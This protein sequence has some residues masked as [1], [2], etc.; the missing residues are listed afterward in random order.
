M[1]KIYYPYKIKTKEEFISDYGDDWRECSKDFS[2]ILAMD[3]LLGTTLKLTSDELKEKWIVSNNTSQ[4]YLKIFENSELWYISE[5]YL[6][7]QTPNYKPKKFIR[8]I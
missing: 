6:V 5:L 3:Y 2:F 8:E 1:N 4:K 7:L